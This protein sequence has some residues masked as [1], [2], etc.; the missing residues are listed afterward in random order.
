MGVS[1]GVYELPAEI[2]LLEGEN[3]NLILSAG[4]KKNGISESI[5]DYPLYDALF[6]TISV[7]ENFYKNYD[8]ISIKYLQAASLKFNEN[9][10]IGNNFFEDLDGN[11]ETN[12]LPIINQ[13]VFEGNKSGYIQ[14]NSQ[15]NAKIEVAGTAFNLTKG[16]KHF[17]ELNYKCNIPFK[18]G[19][20]GNN[21]FNQVIKT[22]ILTINK[23][24]DYNKIYI[25]LNSISD[26]LISNY[27]KIFILA[28]KP[29][30]V[31]IGEIFLDNVKVLEM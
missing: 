25:Q 26:N 29:S 5:I 12:V 11:T 10:E 8:T 19:L 7:N 15:T 18:I 16:K 23:K 14:L 24:T 4:V 30:D 21:E 1:Q 22:P 2:P 28:E 6:D 9:F 17:L 3:K 31:Q 13:N 27:Y 20:V